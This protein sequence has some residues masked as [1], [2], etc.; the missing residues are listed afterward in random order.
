MLDGVAPR[1]RKRD[2]HQKHI[3]QLQTADDYGV[4][5]GLHDI[6][7]C[8]VI[9]R[10]RA[11]VELVDGHQQVVREDGAE[12]EDEDQDRPR[13]PAQVGDGVGQGKDSDTD[14]CREAMGGRRQAV[15][16]LSIRQIVFNDVPPCQQGLLFTT[17]TRRGHFQFFEPTSLGLVAGWGG[18]DWI[19]PV[20]KTF[21]TRVLCAR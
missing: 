6:S 19:R 17:R 10:M 2:Q 18:V 20:R 3:E 7:D 13:D 21:R 8:H 5:P 15:S 4:S 1:D 14:D 11:P 9:R 16:H 12:V